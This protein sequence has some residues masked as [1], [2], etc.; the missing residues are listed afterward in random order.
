V[1]NPGGL[2]GATD[3]NASFR[4]ALSYQLGSGK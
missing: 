3:E 4:V 2:T 1:E